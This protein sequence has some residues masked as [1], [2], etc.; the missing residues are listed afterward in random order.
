[1]A[2]LTDNFGM[3]DNN[4]IAQPA[5][6]IEQAEQELRDQEERERVIDTQQTF[7]ELLDRSRD[8]LVLI[9]EAENAYF[10]DAWDPAVKSQRQGERLPSLNINIFAPA[11]NT[12]VGQERQNRREIRV[13]PVE[14]DDENY[15]ELSNL[16]LK[17]QGR[18]NQDWYY[19][20]IMFRDGIMM[21]RAHQEHYWDYSEDPFGE[22]KSVYRHPISVLRDMDA[23]DPNTL[24]GDTS[25]RIHME[26]LT[27][28]E[29]RSRYKNAKIDWA[30]VSYDDESKR[31]SVRRPSVQG[32]TDS[33]E[34]PSEKYPNYFWKRDKRLIRLIRCWKRDFKTI[35]RLLDISDDS[36]ADFVLLGEFDKERQV[37]QKKLML[38]LEGYDVSS[39]TIQETQAPYWTHHVISGNQE[40]EWTSDIGRYAP[41]TD[42]FAINVGGKAA[43]LW[44]Q[45]GDR[46]RGVNFT[47]T[48]LTERIGR[49]G[50]IPT[51]W[52]ENSFTQ[53]IN[54]TIAMRDGNPIEVKQEVWD[55]LNGQPPFFQPRDN[56][57]ESI[58]PLLALANQ[59]QIDAK[60]TSNVGSVQ[61]GEIPGQ[62]SAASALAI[63]QQEGKKGTTSYGDNL[64][65]AR[66]QKARLRLWMLYEQYR[67]FPNLI[68]KKMIRIFGSVIHDETMNETDKSS[69]MLKL[70]NGIDLDKYL[71][72]I[73]MM[74]YDLILDDDLQ[75]LIE[76]QQVIQEMQTLAA[77]GV[78][79]DP[80]TIIDQMPTISAQSK[81]QLKKGIQKRMQQVEEMASSPQGQAMLLLE[82]QRMGKAKDGNNMLPKADYGVSMKGPLGSANM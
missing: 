39:L 28:R 81:G 22:L 9:E 78:Q 24:S 45:I 8:E 63:L 50:H 21:M 1:M 23:I 61:R 59:D 80:E 55:N 62:V 14:R 5:S 3:F 37:E 33:Y 71:E 51:V 66:A 68:K 2:S 40:L 49:I 56:S 77:F 53:D 57:L 75:S 12:L 74:K 73:R 30:R 36:N 46:Q 34:Y 27:A 38:A 13:M 70:M 48:K 17:H 44:N 7:V 11:V 79:P 31:L 4:L 52:R 69:M 67:R 58:G 64:Q 10:T 35:Y 54:P 32:I 20:N 26:W 43:G 72:S 6:I 65:F 29:L 82:Q 41:W 60:T 25:R 19:D 76:R 18:V 15:A 16:Y 42:F 47:R